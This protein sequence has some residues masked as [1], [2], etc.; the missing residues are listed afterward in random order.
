MR[1]W[2]SALNLEHAR[3]E[4]VRVFC[5]SLELSINVTAGFYSFVNMQINIFSGSDLYVR[6]QTRYLLWKSPYLYVGGGVAVTSPD[7]MTLIVT[8]Q[9]IQT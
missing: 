5:D 7:D 9:S 8:I 6:L 1:V 4:V 2:K 3:G